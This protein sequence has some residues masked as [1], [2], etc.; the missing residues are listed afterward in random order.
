MIPSGNNLSGRVLAS[1]DVTAA[2]RARP[3]YFK[4]LGRY[5]VALRET[6]KWTQS[7]AAK[8]AAQLGLTAVT[9]QILLRMERGQIKDPEPAVLR[10]LASLYKVEYSE[11]TDRL[12]R[13]KYGPDLARHSQAV[14]SPHATVRQGADPHAAEVRFARLHEQH[15]ALL[16][17]FNRIADESFQIV[18]RFR[19]IARDEGFAVPA[20]DTPARGRTRR[21]A[22]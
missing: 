20:T 5:L 16:E 22:G 12:I 4:D 2:T 11:I 13:E 14:Q 6:Q 8:R 7:R 18:S 21:P 9:R 3:V 1:E 10:E 15:T 19:K 17:E